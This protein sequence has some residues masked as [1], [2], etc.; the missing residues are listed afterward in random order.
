MGGRFSG[1]LEHIGELP[2]HADQLLKLGNVH[3]LEV[4]DLHQEISFKIS[5]G[6]RVASFL[7]KFDVIAGRKDLAAFLVGD[8]NIGDQAGNQSGFP[9]LFLSGDRFAICLFPS[10][11]AYI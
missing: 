8:R 5:V 11:S 4:S 2:L 10:K 1:P 9:H 3:I 7:D 6:T